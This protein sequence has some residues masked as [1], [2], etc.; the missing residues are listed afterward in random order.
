M[1][2]HHVNLH[3]VLVIVVQFVALNCTVS[4]FSTLVLVPTVSS[5][6][7]SSAVLFSFSSSVERT[8]GSRWKG[9]KIVL[10]AARTDRGGGLARVPYS[11]YLENAPKPPPRT[12]PVGETESDV[13]KV[14]WK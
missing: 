7:P 14:G 1:M 3:P 6:F 11:A 5:L 13:S 8:S 9:K 12:A 2:K 4:F 10:A